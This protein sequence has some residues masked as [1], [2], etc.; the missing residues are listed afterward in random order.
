MLDRSYVEKAADSGL[1]KLKLLQTDPR[2]YALRSI[3]A[4]MYLTITV[5]AYWTMVHNLHDLAVGKVITS[6]FFGVGLIIIV[7]TNAELF[8]SNTMYLSVSSAEGKTNWKETLFLWTVCFFGN[9]LGAVI[10]AGLLYGAGMIQALPLDHALYTGAAHKVHQA[11]SEIFFKG[12]LANWV[13]C[14]AVRLALRCKED[15]AKIMVMMLVI[16]I[17]VYSGYE[18]SIANLGTFS[19]SLLGNG[20][21]TYSE[22]LHNLLY[23]TLGNIVGGVV[24]LGLP[25]AYLNPTDYQDANVD[26]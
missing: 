14:L 18:H 25:F 24:L 21:I 2:R 8:T 6:L 1:N 3:L 9:F 20:S 22:A 19:I 23:S 13:V 10:V 11:G 15:V 17:F 12:I 26:K 7:F 5:F 16:S 4:G